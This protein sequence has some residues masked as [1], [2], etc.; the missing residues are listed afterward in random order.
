M[1]ELKEI[2]VCNAYK[3]NEPVYKTFEGWLTSTEGIT[4]YSELPDNAKKYI[5]YIENFTE[6]NASI[7][8]TGPSRDQT[9]NR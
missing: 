1:D 4:K 8:S 9:I 2:H 6:C 3:D 7:I 5:E